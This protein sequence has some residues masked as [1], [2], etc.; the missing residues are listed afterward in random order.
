M[1]DDESFTNT[2]HS[3]ASNCLQSHFD[4][5]SVR[6]LTI[7]SDDT[8]SQHLH[9]LHHHPAAADNSTPR[10][11]SR[12]VAEGETRPRLARLLSPSTE[13]TDDAIDDRGVSDDDDT[14]LIHK[15]SAPASPGALHLTPSPG[16]SR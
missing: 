12:A 6:T 16:H 14:I 10:P 3:T 15:A 9:P 8:N 13:A 2:L 5:A 11:A 4:S 1:L 7:G